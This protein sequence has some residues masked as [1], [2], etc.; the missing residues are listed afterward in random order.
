MVYRGYNG[1]LTP[2]ILP[3]YRVQASYGL[4][5]KAGVVTSRCYISLHLQV[6]VTPR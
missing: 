6:T 4:P 2:V 1:H 5:D 3:I